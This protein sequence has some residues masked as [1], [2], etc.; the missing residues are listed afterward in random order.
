M[1]DAVLAYLRGRPG[2]PEALAIALF[3][4]QRAA[5]P[6][7]AAMTMRSDGASP[8]PQGWEDI[9]AIPVSLYKRLSLRSFSGTPGCCFLTSGT[10]GSERGVHELL[11]AAVYDAS[12][13]HHFTEVCGGVPGPVRSLCPPPG[14]DSSLGHMIGHFAAAS[15]HPL[16][17]LFDAAFGIAGAAFERM[18]GP[19]F[20]P[21]TAFS[22]DAVLDPG[23]RAARSELGPESLVMVT[24][25][26]K[27]RR[28]RLDSEAVYRAIAPRFGAPRVV[29]EYGMTELCSQLWTD[30]VPAGAVP[31]WFRA[32]V[33]MHVYTVDPISGAPSPAGG[34]LRFVD[35]ANTDS[36]VAIETM[37]LGRVER[38]VDGDRVWL[39]GRAEGAEL[40]GCS[41][42]A[43]DLL[44]AKNP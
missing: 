37:D 14:G 19:M 16:D 31:G 22:L 13:W 17:Q 7:I 28:V 41:L 11:D 18:E 34:L 33:W 29:G 1:R 9:P 5:S 27:G 40:R 35:L 4:A 8:D 30:P 12:S 38:S 6:L 23:R 10:T 20:L 36:V 21:A 26:F 43:E 24:G 15:G 39:D 44:V 32:P 25:G 42:R 2:D 3:H